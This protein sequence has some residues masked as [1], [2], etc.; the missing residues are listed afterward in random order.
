MIDL[1]A[2]QKG[3]YHDSARLML[4]ARDLGS[5]P[6]ISEAV[7]MMGTDANRELLH[8]AGFA[9]GELDSATPLDLVIALRGESREAVE[10]ARARLDTALSG[11]AKRTGPATAARPRLREALKEHPTANLVSIAVPGTYAAYL[12]HQA[13]DAG[14]NVFLFSDNVPLSDEIALKEKAREM[15]LLLMGPDCGTALIG[16]TGL[17]FANRVMHGPIGLVGASGTG[18][19]ELS[20]LLD[21]LGVGISHAIGTG[22]R[23]LKKSVGGIMSE[24]GLRLLADDEA[25]KVIA[26]V[27]KSP[28]PEVA[29][30]LHTVMTGLGKPVVVRYLGQAAPPSE[31]GSGDATGVF[32]TGSLDEAAQTAVALWR[33]ESV[34]EPPSYAGSPV[35]GLSNGVVVGLFGGG[36]LAAEAALFLGQAGLPARFPDKPIRPGDPLPP[37]THLVIDTGDDFY[38]L[39]KPHPMVDQTVRCDLI[40]KIG[41]DP[42]VRLLLLDL[43]LGDGAHPDPAHEI[44]AAFSEAQNAR[45][46]SPLLGVCTICGTKADPQDPFHQQELLEANGMTVERSVRRAALRAA[47]LYGASLPGGLA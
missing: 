16:G 1:V 45:P 42:S 11:A 5:L 35:A 44:S 13:L 7:V 37:G 40:K 46:Q 9:G 41:S 3:T 19:Q 29:S 23:D 34:P 15:G 38:T 33:G 27:A 21:E 22:S 47:A 12:S 10:S 8:S 2:V 17:G 26:L 6:G 24:M 14:R 20:S 4:I 30:R 28:D 32:Y 36:S 31:P 18:I 39:G 25:T 43:V